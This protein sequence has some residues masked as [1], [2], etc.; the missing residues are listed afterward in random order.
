MPVVV[1][2]WILTVAAAYVVLGLLFAV[3]FLTRGV[4]RVDPHVERS[5][6]ALRLILLP[7]TLAFWPLLLNHWARGLA[8]P[9]E[10]TAHRD[11]AARGPSR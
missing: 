10:R 3:P 2:E 9:V 5:G 11:R 1:A 7:G 8:L 6:V 4:G